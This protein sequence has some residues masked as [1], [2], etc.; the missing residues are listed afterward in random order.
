[1]GITYR[2]VFLQMNPVVVMVCLL[3]NSM[4]WNKKVNLLFAGKKTSDPFYSDDEDGENK[5]TSELDTSDNQGT[6]DAKDDEK[7]SMQALSQVD[8]NSEVTLSI[9]NNKGILINF[10]Q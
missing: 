9:V 4:L 1:M 10:K 2:F 6:S 7:S 5:K 8:S 3:L